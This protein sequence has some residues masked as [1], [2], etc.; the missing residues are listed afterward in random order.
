MHYGKWKKLDSTV[1]SLNNSF[2]MTFW[3]EENLQEQKT[4]QLWP[5][6]SLARVI[7]YK[8]EQSNYVG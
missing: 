6:A 1:Y 7:D 8:G 3:V 2:Y 5:G 4:D